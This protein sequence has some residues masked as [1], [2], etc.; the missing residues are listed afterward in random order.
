[1][2]I[3]HFLLPF[4]LTIAAAQLDLDMAGFAGNGAY[5]EGESPRLVTLRAHRWIV[6]RRI[7]HE[8]GNKNE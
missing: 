4:M 6:T 1:M 7:G 3:R 2:I 5:F 8:A